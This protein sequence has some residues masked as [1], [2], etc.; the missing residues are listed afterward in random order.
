MN[1]DRNSLIG[2]LPIDYKA[3]L[4]KVDEC[5]VIVRG[6]KVPNRKALVRRDTGTVLAI[7]SDM[8]EPVDNRKAIATFSQFAKETGIKFHIDAAWTIGAGA[9]T[10]FEV[11]MDD[12]KLFKGT[13]E[14]LNL[15][16]YLTNSF[17]LAHRLTLKLG[18]L[19]LICLNGMV[20]ERTEKVIGYRHVT[21]VQEKIH[22]DFRTYLMEKVQTAEGFIYRLAEAKFSDKVQ[23]I[24]AINGAQFL[25]DRHRKKVLTLWEAEGESL[26]KWDVY[27]D[28]TNILTHDTENINQQSRLSML[29]R[30]NREPWVE[31]AAN[32]IIEVPRL[33][34]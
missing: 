24:D 34:A 31:S 3:A 20:A 12:F 17:N 6:K 11:K 25:A 2:R 28:F 14:E 30:L 19:R 9:V 29:L 5:P 10:I 33:A 15:R 18:L 22:D 16:G 21:G 13:T 8:Y 27:N 32:R 7:T 26:R 4:F 23:V 1:T